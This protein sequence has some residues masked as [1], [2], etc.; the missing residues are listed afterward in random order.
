MNLN[1]S[2][3]QFPLTLIGFCMIIIEFISCNPKK[4]F[5]TVKPSRDSTSYSENLNYKAINE[6]FNLDTISMLSIKTES[7]EDVAIRLAREFKA[8]AP[9]LSIGSRK[10]YIVEGD[11]RLDGAELY[12]YCQQRLQNLDTNVTER[13]NA[14]KLTVGTD[15]SGNPT[16]W[17]RGTIIRYSIMRNSFETKSYYNKV[18]RNVSAA[19]SDWM[20]TCNVRFEYVSKYDNSDIDLEDDTITNLTFIVREINANGNFIAQSFFPGD[21]PYKR[22]LLIDPSYF[23][24][25]FDSTGVF[26]HEL[27]HVLGYRHEH[28]WSLENAC[29]GES[30]IEDQ[31]GAQQLTKYDPY[32][33]MHYLCGNSGSS[34]LEITE[35]DRIGSIKIYGP[36]IK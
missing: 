4:K 18:V 12:L 2:E 36:P 26:R 35:F 3:S 6:K 28:I 30:I 20:K 34:K 14:G 11:I 8:T 17:P 32:S 19:A 10:Y 7:L 22:M 24:T 1:K 5:S 33:V 23:R 21:P 15:L 9:S 29:K 31:L 25:S 16:I 13:K 27:G